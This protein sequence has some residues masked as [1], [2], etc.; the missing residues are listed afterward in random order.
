MKIHSDLVKKLRAEKHWSQEQLS[1]VCGLNLRTIQRLENTGKASMESVRAL[2]AV[3]NIHPNEL[4]V[5]ESVEAKLATPFDA[6][7]TCVIK[8]A[9]FS[10][11]ANRFEYWWFFAFVLLLLA[12]ATVVHEKA[13]QLVSLIVLLPFIAAGARRLKDTGHSGWWQLLYLVPFGFVALFFMFA[14]ESKAG[15]L[16]ENAKPLDAA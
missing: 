13:Y 9:N 6:V 5:A 14:M 1:E 15:I 12:M 10:D 2:A 4:M 3:F 11:T 7:T 8:Y 16:E